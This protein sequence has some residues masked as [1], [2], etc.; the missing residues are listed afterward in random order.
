MQDFW[1]SF[2]STLGAGVATGGL[3]LLALGITP[4]RK[5]VTGLSFD[6]AT[7]GKIDLTIFLLVLC[8]VLF[9][10]LITSR[11]SYSRFRQRVAENKLKPGELDHLVITGVFRRWIKA[12]KSKEDGSGFWLNKK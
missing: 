9:G 1:K 5:W 10:L 11:I 3:A 12:L 4:L 2:R 8:S 7:K 6:H